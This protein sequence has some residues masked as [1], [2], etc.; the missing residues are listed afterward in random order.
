M[1]AVSSQYSP[2]LVPPGTISPSIMA[3]S[4]TPLPRLEKLS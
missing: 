2:L 4:N 3:T 1:T